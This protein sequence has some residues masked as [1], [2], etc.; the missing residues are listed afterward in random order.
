MLK[1]RVIHAVY[2]PRPYQA[3]TLSPD[4]M[5]GLLLCLAHRQADSSS[6]P[7]EL[8]KGRGMYEGG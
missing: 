8:R 2:Y 3:I 6:T 4:I 5:T 7:D 1:G